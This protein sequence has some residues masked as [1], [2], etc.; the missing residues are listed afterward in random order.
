MIVKP[1]HLAAIQYTLIGIF[2]LATRYLL[3]APVE[4]TAGQLMF[5][6]ASICVFA[7]AV[8]QFDAT[9]IATV[10]MACGFAL[11]S[12]FAPNKSLRFVAFARGTAQKRAAP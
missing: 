10:G 11:W 8:W 7:L 5:I 3:L 12:R 9:L 6:F 4:S 1:H 2:V